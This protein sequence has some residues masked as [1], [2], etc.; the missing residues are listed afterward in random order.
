MTKKDFVAKLYPYALQCQK[1]TGI[2]PLAILAQAALESGWGEVS[3]GNMYFG[4]K[5]TDG[6][7]GNEQL[8]TTTEYS[9]R[10]NYPFPN[11]ISITPVMIGNK[12]MFKYKIKGYF[13]KYKTPAESFIDHGK[14]FMQN[15][16]YA[17]AMKV[18]GDYNKFFDAI[19]A[20]GYATAPTYAK[21]LK[22]IAD[23]LVKYVPA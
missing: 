8:L 6:V 9:S 11:I 21:D 17:A 4:I 5:D 10:A 16:R 2:H 14:F 18:A 13:R 22:D 15:G 12:K 3:P 1:E 23:G 20:A 7:N 19:A